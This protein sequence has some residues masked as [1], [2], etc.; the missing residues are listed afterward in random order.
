MNSSKLTT[1]FI[2]IAT[3]GNTVDGRRI[4]GEELM[5][6]AESYDPAHYTALLWPEHRR[7]TNLGSV[8]ELKAEKQNGEVKLFAVIAPNEQ[9][10]E[11]N[12]AGQGL[13]T[14]VEITPNFGN[15]GKTYLSGLGITDSPASIGTTQLQFFNQQTDKKASEYIKTDFSLAISQ[16]EQIKRGFFNALKQFFSTGEKPPETPPD[17]DNNN[18]KEDSSMDQKFADQVV[19]AI[20]GL[21]VKLDAHFAA[22]A[23]TPS[24]NHAKDVETQ[25][26]EVKEAEMPKAENAAE[27]SVSAAQFNQL[28]D[29][30]QNLDKKFNALSQEKTDV[31][32]GIPAETKTFN[33][34]V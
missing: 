29:A 25:K 14:S 28:L 13:F 32:A 34:A 16:E 8:R 33:V 10:I 7:W 3:S 19:E 21:G 24:T 20:N 27:N 1:D 11:M 12:K 26:A 15:Q 4:T 31:P 23:H 5:E 17:P 22:Q 6:M 30:V 18:K 2:C 9:L